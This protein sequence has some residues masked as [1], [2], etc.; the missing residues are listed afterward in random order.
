MVSQFRKAF[1]LFFRK[2]VMVY[3]KGIT[4]AKESTW[5]YLAPIFATVVLKKS[6]SDAMNYISTSD[7]GKYVIDLSTWAAIVA[8]IFLF[9]YKLYRNYQEKKGLGKNWRDE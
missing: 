7:I 2:I 5:P 8:S 3:R 1:Q 6:A 4:S 9:G